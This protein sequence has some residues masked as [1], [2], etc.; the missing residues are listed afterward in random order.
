MIR[1]KLIILC[2]FV[3]VTAEMDKEV[4]KIEPFGLNAVG[5]FGVALKSEEK[6]V[7]DQVF[8]QMYEE[9]VKV[10]SLEYQNMEY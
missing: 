6:T 4:A 10:S 3:G 7:E 5:V 9:S 1:D 2:L 8:L